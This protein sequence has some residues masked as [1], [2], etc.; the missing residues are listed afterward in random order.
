MLDIF[1]SFLPEV[2]LSLAILFLLCLNARFV[3][4]L[5]SNFP[6]ISNEIFSQISFILLNL[7]II[8]LNLQVEGFFSTLIFVNNLGSGT[9]KA[10]TV[11]TALAVLITLIRSFNI[12]KLNFFEYFLT[13]LL[14]VFALFLLVN[15]VDMLSTYLVI[16]MQALAFYIL[17]CFRRNSAFSTE[18]GLKYFISGSYIS[19]IFLLGCSIIY[20]TFGTLAFS[21]LNY[22]L[23][24]SLT[25]EFESLSFFFLIGTLLIT[26][27]LLFKLSAVPFHFWS[28]D[29][30]EGAPLA[31]TI[32][33]ST[34]PKLALF[35]FLIKWI[36][37]VGEQFNEL[38]PVLLI[39]G[40]LSAVVG[41]FFAI[42][43][44]RLKR[45]IIYSSISQSGFLFA[46][47]SSN[48]LS[49]VVGI[50]FFLVIYLITSVLVWNQIASFYTS[51]SEVLGFFNRLSIKK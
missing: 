2:F 34:I 50:Y 7:L 14:S 20:V 25:G 44:K 30:Y 31:S 11:I 35:H 51:Q 49:S 10:I 18:A 5:H 26:I 13:F 36:T 42:R 43:Q 23:A 29:V 47:L 21:D 3:N 45:L 39:L 24:F 38:R 8:I 27:T 19:G 4:S 48:S 12:Q 32:I 9:I 33:F 16:E 6:I 17:A 1:N 22:L 15:A 41:A 46:A 28:P 37:L 40:L